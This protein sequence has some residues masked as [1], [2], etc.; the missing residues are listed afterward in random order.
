MLQAPSKSVTIGEQPA[1]E[2]STRE[3]HGAG[4][5]RD[6]PYSSAEAFALEDYDYPVPGFINELLDELGK[7]MAPEDARIVDRV[8]PSTDIDDGLLVAYPDES[9]MFIG[10]DPTAKDAMPWYAFV[11]EPMEPVPTPETAQD[12]LDL[13]KPPSVQ[14]EVDDGWMPNRHGEWWLLPTAKV[15]LTTTFRPGVKTRP[16]GPSPLG[17][18][19]PREY[20]F[21]EPEQRFMEQFR[22]NVPAAPKS[23]DTVPEAINW[24]FR[25]LRKSPKARPNYA[26][27]W[28]DIR[29]WAGDVLVKG[30]IRHRD[31]DHFVENVGEQWHVAVTHR[32]EVYTA[33][34]IGEGVHLD[35]YGT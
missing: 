6:S 34:S 32:M 22:E 16:Y 28:A 12:A 11:I 10:K 19:V 25:Q 4:L 35:Y 20:A 23:I 30:T 24:S 8:E 3:I 9:L 13:L 31:D 27:S 5:Q 14:D 29:S 21:T 15:P 1:E 7:E 2:S 26:P 33:D 18:H 17:N